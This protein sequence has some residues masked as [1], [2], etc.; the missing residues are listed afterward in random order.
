MIKSKNPD[1]VLALPHITD[2]YDMRLV[3]FGLDDQERLV[4]AFLY[5]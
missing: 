4:S 2:Y 1:Y 3:T 5:L